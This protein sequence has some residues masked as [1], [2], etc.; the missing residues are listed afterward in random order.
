M[1]PIRL[2]GPDGDLNPHTGDCSGILVSMSTEDERH[3]SAL[4]GE[5]LLAAAE[6]GGLG[7][8]RDRLA[9]VTDNPE[10]R[11]EVACNVAR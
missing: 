5:S 3:T 6:D 2:S 8:L 1:N 4:H 9:E 10:V 7:L 11:A